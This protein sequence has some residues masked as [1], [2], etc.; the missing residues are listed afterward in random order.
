ME[1]IVRAILINSD[2]QDV[3]KRVMN[4]EC[5]VM[6]T[7]ALRYSSLRIH[8][9]SFITLFSSPS[10]L[11]ASVLFCGLAALLSQIH[12]GALKRAEGYDLLCQHRH[13]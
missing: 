4:D 6:N 3:E 11:I 9:S 5:A 1:T 8:H 7:A 12:A 13:R 10:L 2:G